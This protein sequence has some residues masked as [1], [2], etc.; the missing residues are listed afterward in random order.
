[1]LHKG[2][3]TLKPSNFQLIDKPRITKNVFL[4]NTEF[5]FNE[6]VSLD[7]D[8]DIRIIKVSDER[9]SSLVILGLEFFKQ[10]E[11]KDV[12]FKLEMEIEGIFAWDEELDNN[13]E[14]LETL[15]KENGP[16]ILYSY[17]RPII[18]SLTVDACLPP[19]VIPLMNFRE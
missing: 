13:M 16:A 12:P 6:E 18:T 2:E 11:L 5:N 1:M 8:N 7:I 14:Q 19:L 17:L 15:L 9:L 10:S 4:A 3:I